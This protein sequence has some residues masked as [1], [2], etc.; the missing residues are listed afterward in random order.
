MTKVTSPFDLIRIEAP[1]FVAGAEVEK[2]VVIN[3]APILKWM[4]GKEFS[5]FIPYLDRKG[6]KFEGL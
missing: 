1:H 3:T 5:S 2:G 4:R 6:W